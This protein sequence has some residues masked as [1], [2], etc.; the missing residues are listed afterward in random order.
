MV[1]VENVIATAIDKDA[2]SAITNDIVFDDRAGSVPQIDA[3]AAIIDTV[4]LT[5]DDRVVTDNNVIG[6]FQ[7]NA[8]LIKFKM[9]VF[10][11]CAV[12]FVGD[13]NATVFS[14]QNT[15]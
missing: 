3:V 1:A 11:V 2:V 5:T 13:K 12:T 14:F 10:D 4:K 15:T 7:V 8:Y 9:V 6:A